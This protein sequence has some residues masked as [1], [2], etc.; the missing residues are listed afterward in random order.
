M[1]DLNIPI[2]F[3]DDN[4]IAINK[5]AGLLTHPDD[6]QDASSTDVVSLLKAQNQLEYLGIHQRLDREVSGVLVFTLRK[7]ANA[8]LANLFEG[9]EARKEYLAIV[10]GVLPKHAGTIDY[11]LKGSKGQAIRA[12]TRYRVEATSSD[13]RFSLVRLELETGRTHQLRIHL[14]QAGCPIMGDSLYGQETTA[15]FPR[16]L[17]HSVK[18]A[19]P[20]PLTKQ[21]LTIE[22]VPPIVFEQVLSGEIIAVHETLAKRGITAL[23]QEHLP[24]LRNLLALALERRAPFSD[25]PKNTAYRLVNALGDGLPGFSLDR[26]GETLVLNIYEPELDALHPALK[27]LKQAINFIFPGKSLYA[28]F[29][30][31]TTAKLG[32]SAPPEIASPMP[33]SG[34]A[35]QEVTVYENGLK[36]LIRPGEGLSVGLFL[37][38]RQMRERVRQSSS[39]KSVLNC[40]SYTCGFGVA[41]TAGGATRVLNLD[42]SRTALDWG[43]QNYIANGF[44]PDDFDFVFGDVFDWLERFAR[45]QQ[46]FDL[47]ILDPPS[48]SST[49]STRFSA[50]RDY[51]KLVEVAAGILAPG[52]TLVACTNHAGLERKTFRQQVLKGLTTAR[53][54]CP[55]SALSSFEEPQLDFP[56]NQEGYLKII[57]ARPD[58]V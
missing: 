30:P 37:D 40:F 49:R 57:I 54:R 13:K 44:V 48:Y 22:A 46:T 25:D 29:R 42:A 19:F 35:F 51:H 5:P 7:E 10:R 39:V 56:H 9:R 24:G 55:D 38:M 4:L 58:K 3:Q 43:K 14:S 31:V 53:L 6:P 47:V 18:L 11:P 20:H 33:L 23:R 50:E 52:G 27:I 36:Y 15:V 12:V 34:E 17:L 45:K 41:A 16:L 28:K 8:G 1:L 2:L 32:D 26:F 21:N